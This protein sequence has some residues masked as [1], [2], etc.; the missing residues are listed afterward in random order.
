M[1]FGANLHA[2]LDFLVDPFGD[3]HQED[4]WQPVD[5]D[6]PDPR[7]HFVGGRL[8]VVHVED[9]DGDED[10]EA[11]QEHGEEQVFA[12]QGDGQRRGRDDLRNEQ[13][14]HGLREEDGNAQGHLLAGIGRKVKHQNREGGNVNCLNQELNV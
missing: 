3:P 12:E 14:E 9:D 7:R 13:E 10:R 6:S 5:E 4:L 2:F 11:D 1:D 8:A